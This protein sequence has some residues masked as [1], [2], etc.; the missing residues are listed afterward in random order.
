MPFKRLYIIGNGFDLHH[1]IRSSYYAFHDWLNRNGY[2]DEYEV[3]SFFV[4]EQGLPI[5][6]WSSFEA[7]LACF[8]YNAFARHVTSENPPDVTSEH[9]ERTLSD[10]KCEVENQLTDWGRNIRHGL[11]RW[12]SQLNSPNP[13][14]KIKMDETNAYFITFNYTKT[15]EELYNVP[16]E[17]ILHIHG[18]IGREDSELLLGHGGMPQQIQFAKD[19]TEDDYADANEVMAGE[20]AAN[21][22][23]MEFI[24]W[25]KP[26]DRLLNQYNSYFMALSNVEEVF[27][28]GYSFSY[29]DQPYIDRVASIISPTAKWIVSFHANGDVDRCKSSLGN[30]DISFVRLSDLQV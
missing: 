20:D 17:S 11:I 8:N 27:V 22:A 3:E 25:Q 9:F 7:N 6:L 10:A 13:K 23:F 29:I 4:N 19:L 2:S 30:K 1:D 18:E 14:K 16:A 28:F 5:D 21:S 12:A 26:V 24:K 15:L